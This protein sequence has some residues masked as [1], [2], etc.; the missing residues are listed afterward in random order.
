MPKTPKQLHRKRKNFLSQQNLAKDVLGL[1]THDLTSKE[2]NQLGA[3]SRALRSE[4]DSIPAYTNFAQKKLTRHEVNELK[5]EQTELKAMFPVDEPMYIN[6]HRNLNYRPPSIRYELADLTPSLSEAKTYPSSLSTVFNEGTGRFAALTITLGLFTGALVGKKCS[7]VSHASMGGTI[8]SDLLATTASIA[9][10][11]I[12]GSI[13]G[14]VAAAAVFSP[15]GG[16]FALMSGYIFASISGFCAGQLS[17]IYHSEKNLEKSHPKPSAI[18]ITA[19]AAGLLFFGLYRNKVSMKAKKQKL[20]KIEQELN[21][22]KRL[23]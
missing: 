16:P 19:A 18:I 22:L 4:I 10:G 21:G 2:L 23:K 13:G 9:T 3:E 5:R 14:G 20:E 1:I 17:S 11:G 6:G 7:T 12:A 8:T 15:I